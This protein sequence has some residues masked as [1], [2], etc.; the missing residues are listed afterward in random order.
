MKT[1]KL[2]NILALMLIFTPFLFVEMC[3]SKKAATET[4]L[5]DSSVVGTLDTI[6]ADSIS[7]DSVSLAP[8]ALKATEKT[9]TASFWNRLWEGMA[10]SNFHD[11]LH[12]TGFGLLY[13][14]VTEGNF[15]LAA[16]LMVLSTFLYLIALGKLLTKKY[17]YLPMLYGISCLSIGFLV[18][19]FAYYFKDSADR[20]QWGLYLYLLNSIFLV[21]QAFRILR[22]SF[23]VHSAKDESTYMS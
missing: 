17:S 13:F 16:I 5:I 20:M 8:T 15:S 4:I 14:A 21:V 22:F 23:S 12:V 18:I 19:Y 11:G 10:I 9:N 2:A 6:V 1:L 7:I 3:D